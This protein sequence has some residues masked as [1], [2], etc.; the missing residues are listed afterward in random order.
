MFFRANQYR[1]LKLIRERNQLSKAEPG[2]YGGIRQVRMVILSIGLRD[3]SWI[4]GGMMDRKRVIQNPSNFLVFRR[5]F[6]RC[7]L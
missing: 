2:T 3:W 1:F 5:G 6:M 4:I 7:G